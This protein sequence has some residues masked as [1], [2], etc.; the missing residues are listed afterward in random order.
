MGQNAQVML[1]S[2]FDI[3]QNLYKEMSASRASTAGNHQ[4]IFDLLTE[5]GISLVNCDRASFWYWDKKKHELWTTAAVGEDKIVIPENT[6]LVGKAL[7]E[8]KTIITNDPYSCPDFNSN[9]DK[10][11]GYVTKSILCMPISDCKGEFIGVYQ[12]INK[13]GD[14]G[15]FIQGEDERKLSLVAFICGLALE[16]QVF[17]DES[18]H[19][20]LTEIKNRMGL[21]SDYARLQDL[22]N[23]AVFIC[24]IDFFKKVNDTYGHNAG[25]AV[26]KTTARI[27]SE[28]I[29]STDCVYRWGGE[30][31]IVLLPGANKETAIEVA[32][33]VR[34]AIEA[35][36]VY[37]EDMV[38]R[39]TLSIGVAMINPELTLED[40]VKIADGRLYTAKESGRN[41]VISE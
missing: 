3:T 2:I 30:E 16:S 18:Q 40:N 13:I 22:T 32:E 10:E 38:I 29:R 41:R 6:G 20:K 37:F 25:D 4:R 15:K 39:Y 31:F 5:L 1:D 34:K 12:A 35:N 21:Y 23:T 17:L 28:N 27:F 8:Q 36:T 24:D 11:T 26:L 19:D 9:V 7:A 33:R 14:E